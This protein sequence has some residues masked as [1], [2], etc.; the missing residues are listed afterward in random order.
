MTDLILHSANVHT[1]DDARPRATALAIQ[2]ERIIHVGDDDTVLASRTERTKVI[3]LNGMTVLPGLTD[4]H[5]HIRNYGRL[6][7]MVQ[8]Y[9]ARSFDDVVEMVRERAR[10][11]PEGEWIVGRG[12]N[13]ELWPG[14]S[15]PAHDRLSE[16][17]PGH[18]VWLVRVDAHA[19]VANAAAMRS[20]GLDSSVT[21]P[22]GGIVVR[23]GGR[24]TGLFVDDAMQLIESRMPSP[25]LEDV[26]RWYLKAQD[27]CL[28]MGLTAVHEAGLSKRQLEALLVLSRRGQLRMRVYGMLQQSVFDGGDFSPIYEG[29]LTCRS[30]KIV[31][32]GALG[33]RGAAM[34]EPYC[35]SPTEKGFLRVTQDGLRRSVSKAFSSG[36]QV[37]AHA[38]GDL[39]NRSV[40]DAIEAGLG[41][42][43]VSD[44]RS[45]I[46]HAQIVAL[47]DIPRFAG[48]GV[49]AS[50]QPTHCTSDMNMAEARLGGGRIK[51]AYAW[52]KFI[53]AG[54]RIA[55]GSDFPVESPNPL[56]GLYAAVTRQDHRGEPAGGWYPE[57]RMTMDEALRSFTTDAAYAAFEENDKGTLSA[58]NWADLTVVDRDIVAAKPAELLDAGVMA[59]IVGGD[60]AYSR[61]PQLKGGVG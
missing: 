26:L 40:L 42:V 18:P 44:H 57:E 13:Q 22:R 7:E 52:R 25:G 6:Q 54:V 45:R 2:G 49:I 50:I 55:G 47:E 48:L 12:W 37:N 23:A 30:I 56:W 21:S 51:G 15:M 9:D 17:V 28:S 10:D 19:G 31:A 14:K 16:A 59:T 8:L 33:S 60:V 41:E 32:D 39:A 20:A 24:L 34:F 11:A 35:D 43:P 3:D 38:I 4:A 5:G 61:V 27:I 1:L 53:D 29:R 36:F 46:E 58:G